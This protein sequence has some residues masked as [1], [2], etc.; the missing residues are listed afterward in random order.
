M[1][2][3]EKLLVGGF[4]ATAELHD[5]TTNP[6]HKAILR[7]WWR[8]SLLECSGLFNEIVSDTMMNEDPEYRIMWGDE[9][10]IIHGK[11]AVLD[12]YVN[13]A[14]ASVMYHTDNLLAVADWG[15]SDELTFHHVAQG[16]TLQA[17]GYTVPDQERYYDVSTRQVFLWPFDERARVIGERLYEDKS[18]LRIE[19]IAPEEI[20]TPERAREVYHQELLALDARL[21]PDYWIYQPI[22]KSA[23]KR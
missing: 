3:L 18:T 6:F 4:D 8:H 2:R 21:G 23:S 5:R 15:I 13:S 22:E 7:V 19:E 16:S 14:A 1:N 10:T 20:V 17:L 9:A 11:D 12:F